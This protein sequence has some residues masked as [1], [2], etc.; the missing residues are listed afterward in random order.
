MYISFARTTVLTALYKSMFMWILQIHPH[1]SVIRKFVNN[2][3][4]I[5][6]NLD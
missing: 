3:E 6:R 1:I 4:A 2:T 5:D